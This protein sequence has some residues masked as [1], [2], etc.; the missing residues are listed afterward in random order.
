MFYGA[1]CFWT[2]QQQGDHNRHGMKDRATNHSRHA[3]REITSATRR[4]ASKTL[5]TNS[6]VITQMIVAIPSH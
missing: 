5:G 1:I 4:V 6:I 3:S 2:P